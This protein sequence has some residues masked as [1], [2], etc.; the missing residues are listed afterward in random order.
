M[1]LQERKLRTLKGI[2]AGC[3]DFKYDIVANY[4]FTQP[5]DMDESGSGGVWDF[6]GIIADD[7]L[8]EIYENDN[9][10]DMTYQR[11]KDEI[12]SLLYNLMCDYKDERNEDED[13]DFDT[14]EYLE[15]Q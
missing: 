3:C 6:A 12:Q 8:S 2:I 13:E 15:Q 10:D 9:V 1:T 4:D 11:A 5:D 7:C 14:R